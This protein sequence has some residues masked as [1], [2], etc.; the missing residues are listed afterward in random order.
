M[1]R[2]VLWA[3]EHFCRLLIWIGAQ[4]PHDSWCLTE[5]GVYGVGLFALPLA[6]WLALVVIGSIFWV[7]I[8]SGER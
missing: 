7:L 2:W 5:D 4:R 3:G 8:P 1:E 6:G